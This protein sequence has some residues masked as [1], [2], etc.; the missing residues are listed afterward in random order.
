MLAPFV[1]T[2]FPLAANDTVAVLQPVR[3]QGG[4]A[5]QAPQAPHSSGAFFV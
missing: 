1:K 2:G 5:A 3:L 4:H